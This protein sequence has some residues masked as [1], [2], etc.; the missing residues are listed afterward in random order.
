VDDQAIPA[1]GETGRDSARSQGSPLCPAAVGVAVRPADLRGTYDDIVAAPQTSAVTA[2][3]PST[4]AP[5]STSA[6]AV[7]ST[8][9]PESTAPGAIADADAGHHAPIDP[10][11]LHGQHSPDADMA[12]QFH[13]MWG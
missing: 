13:H 6:P 2:T 10:I 3:A 5:T 4:P 7:T 11:G 8:L 12:H 1:Q 9:P